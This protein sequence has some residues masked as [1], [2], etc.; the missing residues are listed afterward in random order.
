MT[1]ARITHSVN[2]A[3]DCLREG[4]VV[5][6]PTETVYG[7]AGDAR[8]ETAIQ[9]IFAIKGRPAN[10]PL[11]VH[12]ATAEEAFEW[13]VEI[14]ESARK[15]AKAFWPGPL[16]LVLRKQKWVSDSLTAG[17]A[18]VAVRVPAHPIAHQLLVEFRGAL[19]APSA[20]R[21]TKVSP[22]STAHVMHDLSDRLELILE[23]GNCEIGI[24]STIIDCSQ[25]DPV[26]LRPG[27][28][29]VE[30]LEAVLGKP[31]FFKNS[32]GTLSPGQHAI[33]YAPEA[34]L[35]LVNNSDIANVAR[36]FSATGKQVL[37]I[38]SQ[39]M[40]PSIPAAHWLIPADPKEFARRIY[41]L[42][43]EADAAKFDVVLTQFPSAQGIGLAL[44][45]RLR[46]AAKPLPETIL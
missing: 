6:I 9:K 46:R 43:R 37:V 2:E 25:P 40:S 19:A 33:H 30:E 28:V 23:G 8:N 3:A 15:L 29:T 1:T 7:L 41:G 5:A 13:T 35:F 27:Y 26:L 45:D 32:A 42:L 31:I 11:I 39:P 18:T 20:N 24:E 36:K 14:N 21:F 10:H 17:Q 44:A 16:S 34:D 12:F 38:S 22:T 4:G